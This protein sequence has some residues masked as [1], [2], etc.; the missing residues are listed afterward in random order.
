MDLELE[1]H[2][3][4]TTISIAPL[5]SKHPTYKFRNIGLS[6]YR[7][8][9]NRTHPRDRRKKYDRCVVSKKHSTQWKGYFAQRAPGMS[10]MWMT[11]STLQ[12]LRLLQRTIRKCRLRNMKRVVPSELDAS[13]LLVRVGFQYF[14]NTD[15]LDYVLLKSESPL[16]SNLKFCLGM[17]EVLLASKHSFAALSSLHDMDI[18]HA[19]VSLD[20]LHYD[21][22]SNKY[23]LTD[24][25]CIRSAREFSSEDLGGSNEL[26][27]WTTSALMHL[28]KSMDAYRL[29]QKFSSTW[30]LWTGPS[31]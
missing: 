26:Y 7:V 11:M 21:A 16:L 29:I 9:K 8:L 23:L 25:Y 28:E 2:S 20:A 10:E 24:L 5:E 13:L 4:K 31:Y 17:D 14:G 18:M 12:K 30:S 15:I 3:G 1:E 22:R 6:D 27:A 19:N